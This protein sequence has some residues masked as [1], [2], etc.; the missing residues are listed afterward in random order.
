VQDNT[1]VVFSLSKEGEFKVT[2]AGDELGTIASPDLCRAIVR[3]APIK[4]ARHAMVK[5]ALPIMTDVPS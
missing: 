1:R 3:M 4:I 2:V 5:R